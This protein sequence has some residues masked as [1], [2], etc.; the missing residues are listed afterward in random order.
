M[1]KE[2]CFVMLV[3]EVDRMMVGVVMVLVV[4]LVLVIEMLDLDM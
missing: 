3:V 2:I 1:I 4:M